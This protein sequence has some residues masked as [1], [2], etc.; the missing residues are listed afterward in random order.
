M[1]TSIKTIFFISFFLSFLYSGPLLFCYPVCVVQAP[2]LIM[3]LS[4]V[5]RGL[6]LLTVQRYGDFFILQWFLRGLCTQTALLLTDIKESAHYRFFWYFSG[7]PFVFRALFPLFELCS[8]AFSEGL[9]KKRMLVTWV[10]Q[11][12]H[13][14]CHIAFATKQMCRERKKILK[15][16]VSWR[17]F[18]TF[19]THN[20]AEAVGAQPERTEC[21]AFQHKNER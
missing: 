14:C 19:A 17:N 3:L 13:P 6:F 18:C 8:K 15:P 2:T 5:A 16:L 20:G 4:F 10:L 11:P 1:A 12:G 9:D 21:R 7:F